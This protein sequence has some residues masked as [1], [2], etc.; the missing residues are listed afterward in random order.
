MMVDSISFVQ[1]GLS[2][3][4]A[5]SSPTAIERILRGDHTVYLYLW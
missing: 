4:S 3:A 5:C 2:L 1:I